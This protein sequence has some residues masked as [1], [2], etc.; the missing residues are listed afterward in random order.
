MASNLFP[1]IP[2]ALI[3]MKFRT[4]ASIEN[5][6]YFG[7]D[8]RASSQDE[9]IGISVGSLYVGIYGRALWAGLLGQD[10]TLR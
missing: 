5:L 6:F 9:R 4:P 2:L 7:I 1:R 3:I 10:G 8:T